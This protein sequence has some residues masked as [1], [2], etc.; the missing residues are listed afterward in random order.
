MK[1]SRLSPEWKRLLGHLVPYRTKI[2]FTVLCTASTAAFGVVNAEILRRMVKAAQQMDFTAI[3]WLVATAALLLP[4]LLVVNYYS[5]V[6][7]VEF[8]QSVLRDI[9]DECVGHL[10]KLPVSYLDHHKTGEILSKLNNDTGMIQGFLR[11]G[12]TFLLFLPFMIVFYLAYLL[13][14]SPLLVVVSFLTFPVLM[15]LG[16][17]MSNRFKAGSKRYMAFM[18]QLNNS[19]SDMIGGIAMVKVFGLKPF[20]SRSYEERLGQATRQAKENDGYMV[21]A[22]VF[23][24]AARNLGTLSCLVFGAWMVIEGQLELGALVA[25]YAVLVLSLQPIMDLAYVSFEAKSALAACERVF[26]V[27][28][29]PVEPQGAFR[30]G[31]TIPPGAPLIRFDDVRF[32]YHESA[33]V[34]KGVSFEVIEGQTVALVGPSG[35]GKTSVLQLLLG[36]YQ[37]QSGTISFEGRSLEEWDREA[38]RDRLAYVP[39]TSFLFPLTVHE[40]LA[41]GREGATADEVRAAAKLAHAAEFIEQI[42]TGYDSPVTERGG[43]FSGGQNQRLA[44]A[45]SFLK[46]APVLLL[47]EA[48][49]S[50]DRQS[51]QLVQE[52]LETLSR[53]RTVLVVAH[54]LSTV[55][56]ADRIL[57]LDQG[58]IQEAGTSAELLAREGLFARL[59]AAA[60]SGDGALS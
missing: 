20:L 2:A 56:H 53:R 16:Y 23:H 54:R 9:R 59:Y 3:G 26:T 50:L 5:E 25:F 39:Q 33:P 37:P 34:L 46:D 32:A 24:S 17:Q 7:A 12:F 28:D 57:V 51:E 30:G 58:V 13:W 55:E 52:A 38:L 48:T 35:G 40:N 11:R 36:F 10:T 41:L 18:G 44:I 45:R 22:D 27:L 31:P 6:W 15:T 14:L 49:A 19:I 29:F 4:V 8:S 47:D 1:S 60:R 42:P 21:W 43:N